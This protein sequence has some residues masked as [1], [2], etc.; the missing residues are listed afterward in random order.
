MAESPV[1]GWPMIE[2]SGPAIPAQSVSLDDRTERPLERLTIRELIAELS[3]VEGELR[4]S[5]FGDDRGAS[6]KVRTSSEPTHLDIVAKL[7]AREL[8]LARELRRRGAL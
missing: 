4:R 5:P 1:D 6:I 7:A 2:G 8:D 3:L